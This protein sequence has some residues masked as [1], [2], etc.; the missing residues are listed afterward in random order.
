MQ[1]TMRR[2]ILLP[3]TKPE[4]EWLRG[5]A[6]R[7]VSPRRAHA[8]LQRWWLDNLGAWAESR[9]EVLP[10]WRFRVAP[11]GEKVRP[12]VPDVSYLSYERDADLTEAEL[13]VPLVPP[14][15][16]VE[17]RSPGDSR[18]DLEDKVATLLR[19]GTDVVV[20]VNPRTRT[21]IAWDREAKR[22]FSPG[23]RFEHRALPGF[24]FDVEVMFDQSRFRLPP[25]R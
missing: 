17:I 14:N 5:R 1:S 11:P 25:K 8:A 23:E 19:A 21:V 7:K 24:G 3:E 9:G 4:T 2:E 18:A 12:L 16:A 10:E 20:I 6:V 22:I 15:A 13:E